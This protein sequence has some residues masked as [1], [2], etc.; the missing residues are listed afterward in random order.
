MMWNKLGLH[1][2]HILQQTLA[3]AKQE[4]ALMFIHL[5]GMVLHPLATEKWFIYFLW[6]VCEIMLRQMGELF[7]AFRNI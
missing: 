7:G 1:N 3:T 5:Y 6:C 2:D 4:E